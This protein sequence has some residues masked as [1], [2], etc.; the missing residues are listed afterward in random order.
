M[1]PTKRNLLLAFIILLI[2]C[3]LVLLVTNNAI[4][5]AIFKSQLVLS[6]SSGSYPMWHTLPEPMVASM[7]LFKVFN[8][9]NVSKG[10]KPNLEQ[11]G[12]YVFTEQH[13]KTKIV[14][15]DNGTVT[16]RQIRTWHFLPDKSNG[17]LED[18]V[19]I[20]NS[21]AASMGPMIKQ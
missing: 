7:Y 10:A 3:G 21:V 13:E 12:P 6:P 5:M 4:Y 17:T 14:W 1:S 2:A 20:L 8:P 18:E 16:Y 19:T 11:V 15:N 9:G